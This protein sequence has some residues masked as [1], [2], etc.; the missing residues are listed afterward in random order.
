MTAGKE[1]VCIGIPCYKGVEAEILQDYMRFMYYLGRRYQ[2]YDFFL[3]IKPKSEQFRARNAIV[4]A[5][6][7]VGANWL[8]MMDD[9]HVIDWEDDLYASERYEFLRTMIGHLKDDPTRG[10]V[11]ALYYTRGGGC[12]PVAMKEG[13]NGGYFWMHDDELTRG[14]QQVAVT[15]G[16]CFAFN[17]KMFEK[18]A[19]PWFEPEQQTNGESLGTDLQI[20]KKAKLAGYT[21]WI[22]TTIEIGHLMHSSEIVTPRNRHRIA[23]ERPGSAPKPEGLR[24]EWEASG[25]WYLYL[26]DVQEYLGKSVEEL[27][28]MAQEYYDKRSEFDID[29]PD[30][31]YRTRGDLQIARQVMFHLV[32]AQTCSNNGTKSNHDQ[33]DI[34]CNL[35]NTSRTGYGV[36]Y[37]CGSSP[38]GFELAMR[39]HRMDFIDV[40]DAP[41]TKFIRW[42]AKHRGIEHRCGYE[43]TG[44]YDYALFMDSIEH[45]V[46]WTGILRRV[47]DSLKPGGSIITNYFLNGDFANQ[48]HINMD[49]N[50]VY[51]YL[52][53]LG[54]F[55]NNQ[56]VFQK[57]QIVIPKP[58]DST[59]FEMAEAPSMVA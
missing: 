42:R 39:G 28:A 25:M 16:G 33:Y 8:L 57:K 59:V 49:H 19:H 31:Y 58:G 26:S 54:M 6:M 20:C 23:S 1:R 7:Q 22:D 47:V 18:I 50:A 34:F 46:D 11:G 17:M 3:A 43:L 32:S 13:A 55:P 52:I 35:I 40:P 21:V 24:K 51:Q 29:N 9:D 41:G 4:E 27:E 10:I 37:G 53:S 30:E 48:E 14:L 44:P 12:A 56:L 38:L 5:A 2:E 45:F 36:D 15:G